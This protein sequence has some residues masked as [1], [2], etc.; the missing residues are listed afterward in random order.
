MAQTAEKKQKKA[1]KKELGAM[2]N[3]TLDILTKL[4]E[5]T[6]DKA[7]LAEV[8]KQ[9]AV[10]KEAMGSQKSIGPCF[11]CKQIKMVDEKNHEYESARWFTCPHKDM[12]C[13]TCLKSS[14]EAAKEKRKEEKSKKGKK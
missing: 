7:L 2:L 9:R 11:G 4:L 12:F 10:A 5:K 1:G 3:G 14:H 13:P 8:E 6:G